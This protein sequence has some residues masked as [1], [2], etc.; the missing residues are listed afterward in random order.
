MHPGWNLYS[1]DHNARRTSSATAYVETSGDNLHVLLNTYVTRVTPVGDNSTDFRGVEFAANAQSNRTTIVAKKE[2]IV[3]GG[4]FGSP[5]I[6]MN[7]GIGDSQ[8]L[9]T[10]GVKT[11]VD[12]PSVG[13]NLTDQVYTIAT[14]NTS[15]PSTE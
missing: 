8:E 12:N 3:S 13:K 15:L 7:S 11:L 1:I 4:V 5:Q 9:E 10:V 14:F 2:V 6:L